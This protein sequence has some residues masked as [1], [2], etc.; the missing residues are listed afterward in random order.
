ML[1]GIAA[2]PVVA[3]AQARPALRPAA[4]LT[5]I[6]GDVLVRNARG[7]FSAAVDGAVLYGGNVLRTSADARALIT[8]FEGST[9]ELDPASDITIEDASIGDGSTIA[10]ALGRSWNVVMHLTSADS[11]YEP[12]TPAATASV[13]GG[14]Y[15]VASADALAGVAVTMTTLDRRVATTVAVPTIATMVIPART[16][17]VRSNAAPVSGRTTVS[18]ALVSK[19]VAQTIAARAVSASRARE[20]DR[21]GDRVS[22]QDDERDED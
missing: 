19:V 9:M 6:S 5:V 15:E 20:R 10:H 22:D 17:A 11:R 14:E 8:L 18:T 2:S 7:D 4:I 12:S 13:R 21:S 1:F 16:T 3:N